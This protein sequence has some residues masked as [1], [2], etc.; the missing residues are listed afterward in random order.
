MLLL[1]PTVGAEVDNLVEVD[2]MLRL[3]LH[4]VEVDSIL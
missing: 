2:G 4:S 3:V 1:T